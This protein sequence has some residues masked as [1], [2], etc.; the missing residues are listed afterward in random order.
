[1]IHRRSSEHKQRTNIPSSYYLSFVW[2]DDNFLHAAHCHRKPC[3]LLTEFTV[4]SL[5]MEP[6]L[7]ADT[8]ISL[9]TEPILIADKVHCH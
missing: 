9:M 7:I 8:V 5:M 4:I 6:I 2:S 1:M 3:L